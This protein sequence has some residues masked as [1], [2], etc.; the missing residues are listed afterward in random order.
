MK[1]GIITFWDSDDNYGQLFQ[2]FALQ[3]FLRGK[4]HEAS[5]IRYLP[6]KRKIT[7]NKLKP[8]HIV[9]YI[10][11]LKHRDKVNESNSILRDFT[12]FRTGISYTDKIY[13]GFNELVKED[14][15]Q[16]DCFICGSDQIWSEKNDEQLRSYFLQFAPFQAK[17]IAYAPSFG[18]NVI[19]DNYKILLKELIREFDFISVREES[20]IPLINAAGRDAAL[21]CDPTFLLSAEDYIKDKHK[22]DAL[23]Q[24]TLFCYFINWEMQVDESEIFKFSNDHQLI[25]VFFTTKD[26]KPKY[27]KI[28]SLQSPEEWLNQLKSSAFSIINSFHGIVFSILFHIPFAVV[29]LSGSASV[30]NTRIY[31]LLEKLG[32]NDRIITPENPLEKIYLTTIN[33][34]N[35]DSKLNKFRN[36]SINFIYNALNH[37]RSSL[38][39]NLNICFLTNGSVH[40]LY[41]GLDRVTEDL[42]RKFIEAGHN[43]KF[44]SFK[45][46]ETYHKDLQYFFPNES[47]FHQDN[48]NFFNKFIAENKIDIIINQEGNVNLCLPIN[49]PNKP[50]LLSCLHFNP[51]YISDEH[52]IRK[53]SH[54]PEPARSFFRL[55][56]KIP[57]INRS[58]LSY[59]KNK[60]RLNYINNL[61]W[62]DKFILLSPKFKPSILSLLKSSQNIEKI[63]A[64]FNPLI[65]SSDTN[66]ST[67]IKREK[68]IIYVGRLDNAF[69]RVDILI[70][71]IGSVLKSHPDWE[72]LIY[73]DGPDKEKLVSLA[74]KTS[75]QI[76]LMGFGDTKL[77]YDKA[78][79]IVMSS[80]KSEGWGLVLVEAMQK[81]VVPLATLSYESLNDIIENEINGL[82]SS[83]NPENFKLLLQKLIENP[84]KLSFM[85]K[86]AKISVEKFDI[87][88]IYQEWTKLFKL[89]CFH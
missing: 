30:M 39:Y 88:R 66:D 44:L 46:R 14:W 80:N 64:I 69:K 76:K 45:K 74:S 50:V 22:V 6:E 72:F 55:L 17:K 29:L 82:I 3:K 10:K 12:T 85:S 62:A 86:N 33:W 37:Q 79:I 18:A 32:L 59:L 11:Y 61:N 48:I 60:L 8:N 87:N 21:V 52:F 41:G 49:C 19:S 31:S 47:I 65:P 67:S 40:H 13:I 56:F 28:H 26:Y 84:V 75:P 34:T 27:F 1:I 20:G 38:D 36:E 58:G 2:S 70:K 25:P 35:V 73:G 81:G 43:V 53:F 15:A 68:R 71:N 9:N 89:C 51:N 7:L 78:S 83:S 54:Y 4:G 77:I 57:F 23:T 5:V 63:E 42:A 24:N 16:Y